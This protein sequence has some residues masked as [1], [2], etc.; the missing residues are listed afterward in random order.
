MACSYLFKWSANFLDEKGS[1]IKKCEKFD[2][3]IV[4]HNGSEN[5]FSLYIPRE[6]VKMYQIYL[7]LEKRFGYFD[8]CYILQTVAT[9]R[10]RKKYPDL[11]DF[12]IIKKIGINMTDF[13]PVNWREWQEKEG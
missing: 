12:E 11:T 10:N 4:K 1:A 3:A 8:E 7:A 9:I 13:A 6:G 5:F 2:V